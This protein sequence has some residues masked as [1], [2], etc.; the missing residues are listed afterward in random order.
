MKEALDEFMSAHY[1]SSP[2]SKFFDTYNEDGYTYCQWQIYHLSRNCHKF[3]KLHRPTL[4]LFHILAEYPM[5]NKM[6]RQGRR[7][8][9]SHHTLLHF[10]KYLEKYGGLQKEMVGLLQY[11]G[12]S[13]ND[14]DSEGFSGNSYLLQKQMAEQDV[15]HANR[16]THEYK[17][18]EESLFESISS[19]TTKCRECQEPIAKYDDL[20]IHFEE[21][22]ALPTYSEIRDTM[23]NII[24]KREECN[25]IYQRYG[26]ND[27]VQRHQYVVERYR[28]I[29]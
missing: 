7:D 14:E 23:R 26:N 1:L 11:H 13:M 9:P 17:R 12:L 10:I 16:L 4:W 2:S 19:Y 6:I 15:I 27:N 21:I 5:F 24:E 20:A 29:I 3:K 25:H 8:D 28:A 18:M 22:R